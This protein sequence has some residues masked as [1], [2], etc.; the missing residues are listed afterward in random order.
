MVGIGDE[1]IFLAGL[2]V[3]VTDQAQRISDG[4]KQDGLTSGNPDCFA[5]PTF[6]QILDPGIAFQTGDKIE[7][8][9]HE[10]LIPRVVGKAHVEHRHGAAGQTQRLCPVDLMGFAV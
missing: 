7:A 1:T 9:I 4:S 3:Q 10:S 6:M 2:R 8:I 5:A